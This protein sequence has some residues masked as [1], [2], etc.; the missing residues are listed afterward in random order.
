VT[1]T[2]DEVSCAACG[3]VGQNADWRIAW[4]A[5]ADVVARIAI[6]QQIW[7]EWA[8]PRDRPHEPAQPS[9]DVW[10]GQRLLQQVREHYPELR[11]VDGKRVLDV[12]ATLRYGI[13][14]VKAG[15][16]RLDQ[17]EVT[18]GSQ[19]LAV[20]RLE[21]EGVA[22]R[23]R[24]FFHTAPAEALPFPDQ[25]FD[26]VFS[27]GTIAHTLR[28]RSLPELVRVLRPGGVMLLIVAYLA[29][30]LRYARRRSSR[31]DRSKSGNNDPVGTHDIAH[32]RRLLDDVRWAP[33]DVLWLPWGQIFGDR[34][35]RHVNRIDAALGSWGGV[36]YVL[37][38]SC[39]VAGRKRIAPH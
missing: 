38:T 11:D 36:A 12:G 33:F 29:R 8:T 37:G 39:W 25:A 35:K 27:S 34:G 10:L 30:P 15:A 4:R 3:T 13:R 19:E 5:P 16:A 17:V 2:G 28:E 9:L 21:H 6:E 20:C 31:I 1:A 7:G 23:G 32:V 26:V 24:V 14:F 22:W 18:V